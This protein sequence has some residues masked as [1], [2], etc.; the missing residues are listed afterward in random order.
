MNSSISNSKGHSQR[1]A[2]LAAHLR[3]A[4]GPIVFLS[5]V[6]MA[7]SLLL[8]AVHTDFPAASIYALAHQALGA[9]TEMIAIGNSLVITGIQPSILSRPSVN[10]AVDGG[11]YRNLEM[12]VRRNLDRGPQLKWALIQLDLLCHLYGHSANRDFRTL[13]ELGVKRQD[14]TRNPVGYGRQFLVDNP[15]LY[16]FFSWSA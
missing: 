5:A 11:N 14:I 8:R 15:I 10:L 16:P 12:V 13:Y 7:G 3:W 4:T 9:K 1:R 6:V 2:R